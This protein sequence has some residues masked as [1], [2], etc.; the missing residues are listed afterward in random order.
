[1]GDREFRQID[2]R[3]QMLYIL[4]ASFKRIRNNLVNVTFYPGN[5][6]VDC[7]FRVNLFVRF[8]CLLAS[9]LGDTFK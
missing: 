8:F 1:M 4:D 2:S 5:N 6:F 7:I 3:H 9:V